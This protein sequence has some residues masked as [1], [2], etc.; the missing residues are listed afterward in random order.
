MSKRSHHRNSTINVNELAEALTQRGWQP[1]RRDMMPNN[2]PMNGGNNM[3][4]GLSA[5]SGILGAVNGGNMPQGNAS[6]MNI[7]QGNMMMPQGMPP[8]PGQKREQPP[9][10][11][12]ND[13]LKALFQQTLQTLKKDI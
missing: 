6:P 4:N 12:E 2:M 11:T 3:N 9:R 1:P 7:P 5:L 10:P 8:I 13:L